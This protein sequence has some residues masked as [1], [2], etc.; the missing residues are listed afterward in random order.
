[1]SMFLPAHLSGTRK[2][3]PAT[4]ALVVTLLLSVGA[5]WPTANALISAGG[6]DGPAALPRVLLQTAMANTPAPG[7]TMS[8]KSGESLQAVLNNVK[9]GDT[10]LLESGATFTGVFTFPNKG[11]DDAHWIIVRTS[12]DNSQLPAEGS[13]LTPCYAGV[14]SLPGRPALNCTF[15]R[16]VLAKLVMNRRY[17]SGPVIFAP[18]ASHY[19]LIGLEITRTAGGGLVYALASPVGGSIT[20]KIIYDRL[21]IHGTAH[22]ETARGVQ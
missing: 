2:R 9:C 16:N 7:I 5:A 18:G 3:M 4:I 17:S 21:W 6:F 1:M 20:R 10:I 8:V 13:R 11:C 12:S 22:D 15:V 14:S 19:R